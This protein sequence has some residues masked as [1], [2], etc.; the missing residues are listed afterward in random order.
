LAEY[1]M[2]LL[3]SLLGAILFL[4]GWATPF[5]NVGSF[6][7]GTWT[8]G[9]LGHWSALAWGLF[10]LVTKTFLACFVMV[11]IRWTFPRLRTDQLMYLCWKVLIPFSLLAFLLVSFWKYYQ[12]V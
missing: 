11:W 7:L 8:S 1:A 3:V 9:T 4:G 6:L 12:L 10:W 2:M 5:P